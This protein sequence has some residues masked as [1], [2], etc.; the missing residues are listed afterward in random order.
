M[1]SLVDAEYHY[2]RNGDGSEDLFAP[3]TDPDERIDLAARPESA[4][5][6]RRLGATL[7]ALLRRDR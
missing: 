5:V 6:L 2:I 1:K 3:Q 7:E 4:S